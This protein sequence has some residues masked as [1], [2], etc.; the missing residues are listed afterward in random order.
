MT[1]DGGSIDPD[2]FTDPQNHV[3]YLIWKNDG[4]RIGSPTGIWSA[5]LAP[6]LLSLTGGASEILNGADESWQGGIIE[7]PDMVYVSGGFYLF[8]SGGA[9]RSDRLCPRM[10]QLRWPIRPARTSR[11]RPC[12]PPPL[13]CRVPGVPASSRCQAANW[14]WRS[15]PGRATRSAISRAV[16]APCTWPT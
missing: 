1:G 14:S 12:S 11:P 3:A 7:G 15:L 9:L 2:I 8:F 13:A 4:N 6:N 16:S 10:G 5:P